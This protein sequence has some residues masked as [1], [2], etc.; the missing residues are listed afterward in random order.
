MRG[1]NVSAVLLD[2]GGVV[3]EESGHERI[4]RAVDADPAACTMV[5]DRIDKEAIPAKQCDAPARRAGLQRDAD[6][7]V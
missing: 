2:V 3:L 5:G 6:P 1:A 7:W 4:E